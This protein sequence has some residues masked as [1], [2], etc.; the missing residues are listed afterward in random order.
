[1]RPYKVNDIATVAAAYAE[2]GH[3]SEG[4]LA[5]QP[6]ESVILGADLPLET[7]MSVRPIQYTHFN[8][9]LYTT[10]LGGIN[11][12]SLSADANA[13]MA[14]TAVEQSTTAPTFPV[15]EVMDK[16][17]TQPVSKQYSKIIFMCADE[18]TNV[19]DQ[20]AMQKLMHDDDE[21]VIKL[22][23][24]SSDK[25]AREL[26]TRF[27]YHRLIAGSESG[28]S[29]LKTATRVAT[30]Q[31][32]EL[33]IVARLLGLP[34]KDLTSFDR[35]FLC[36]YH[37]ICRLLKGTS[38]DM[39]TLNKL[40]MG[41]LSGHLRLTNTDVRNKE[42]LDNYVTAAMDIREQFRPIVNVRMAVGDKTVGNW[43]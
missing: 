16:Y 30:T 28:V 27:G 41:D 29:L 9:F 43:P 26:G 6:L 19:L 42:L 2:A 34:V 1:M 13:R 4:L 11:F 33:Y 17:D 24:R 15:G 39:V 18:S 25:M 14:L 10:A 32:C 12:T 35:Q 38:A 36:G 21:W 22:H 31:T 8:E 40:F 7:T 5:L 3:P 23:P 37:H 20:S